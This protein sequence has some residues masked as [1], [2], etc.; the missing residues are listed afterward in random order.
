MTYRVLYHRLL[1]KNA[2]VQQADGSA[3]QFGEF[4]LEHDENDLKGNFWVPLVAKQ[5]VSEETL[6]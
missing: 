6:I 2:Q 3:R 1:L 5:V 4:G